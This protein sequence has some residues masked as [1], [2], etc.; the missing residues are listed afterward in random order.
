MYGTQLEIFEEF[1][2]R[3]LESW[4]SADIACCDNCHDDFLSFWP[5][6]NQANDFDF[7]RQGIPLDSFYS[8]SRLRD[9]YTEDQFNT[10]IAQMACPR[11]GA[12]LGGNIWPYELPFNVPREFETTINEVTALASSTPFLLLEH[13]FCK[14]TIAAIRALRQAVPVRHI[15]T[16]L[17]RARSLEKTDLPKTLATF[18]FPP[19][20]SVHEGRYNHAGSPVLYLASDIKTCQAELR[21]AR[22]LVLEFAL[23]PEIRILDLI[24]PLS[25][26]EEH[27]DL[28]RCLVYSALV[29]AKQTNQG[30]HKPH[31]VVSRFVA[32]CA[33]NAG[34][35]AIKYPS[36][37]MEAANFNL[38]LVNQELTLDT[39]A[40][41]LSYHYCEAI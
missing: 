9:H 8:G 24:D 11:C 1:F 25:V 30:L 17:F 26:D 39:H 34:F 2:Y 23:R 15:P 36:T 22:C 32:D 10:F 5:H 33:R 16:S 27:T 20:Q 14:Q 21:G 28:L 6:A 29:S 41:A 4:F 35:D 7:Q 3:D 12:P 19:Q 37:R 31:Y 40:E 38:V 18:D 13:D